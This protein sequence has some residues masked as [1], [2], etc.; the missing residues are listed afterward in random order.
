MRFWSHHQLLT[1]RVPRVSPREMI[2]CLPRP[3]NKVNDTTSFNKET[4]YSELK[5]FAMHALKASSSSLDPSEQLL[6]TESMQVDYVTLK[7]IENRYGIKKEDIP[8]SILK[9]L[10]DN[11][12][13]YV[14]TLVLTNP[15]LI[16]KVDVQI[17]SNDDRSTLTVSNPEK[18]TSFTLERIQSIFNYNNLA[19]TKR[20]QH[21]ISR[22]AIGNGLKAI[23][24][25]SYALAT[26]YYN[27][28]GWTP[29]RIR[30]GNKQY[31]VSLVV[32]K[33]NRRNKPI[34]LDVRQE[35]CT[36]GQNTSVEIDIPTNSKNCTGF[37][38]V[39]KNF[40]ILNPHISMSLNESYC[41]R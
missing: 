30:T 32:D 40:T 15:T 34:S 4:S 13:D 20:N 6:F 33:L 10:V 38:D 25:M 3:K 16:P 28:D 23:L 9:E 21:K 35:E 18:I 1:T 19:S 31:S 29:L 11:S 7:G 12:L 37:I 39:F 24:G 22:G 5:S 8:V 36:S 41:K 26:E 27:H 14:E 17:I 2:N